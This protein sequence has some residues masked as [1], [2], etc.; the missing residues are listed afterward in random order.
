MS[1]FLPTLF[2]SLNAHLITTRYEWVRKPLK[3]HL[4]LSRWMG[5]R[6]LKK[7]ISTDWVVIHNFDHNLKLKLDRSRVM[8]SALYWSGL[9]EVREFIYLHR[10]LKKDMVAIDVGA[11]LGEYT[12][13]MAKRLGEGSVYSF[14]P[15]S[16]TRQQLEENI[17]LNQFKNVVV[18]G[19]GLSD[20]EHQL[21]IHEVDD[22]HEGLAT[23]YLG[24]RKVKNSFEVQLKKLDD[25]IESLGIKKI[26]FIKIDVEGSELPALKGSLQSI[27]KWK[28]IILVEV[29]E[30][31][32]RAAGYS[33][34]E[35]QRFFSEINYKPHQISKN[36]S[37]VSVNKLPAFGNIVFVPS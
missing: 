17:K 10:F 19:H 35:L 29:N 27:N 3:V 13:F 18:V 26:D 30:P 32:Y 7:I 22:A 33:L 11:N 9:H 28:P 31:T 21:Q 23:F 5:K 20:R 4:L 6:S 36:G 14:E 25:E 34:D 12:V 1:S 15:M 8:G 24:D 16:S 37:L 2:R